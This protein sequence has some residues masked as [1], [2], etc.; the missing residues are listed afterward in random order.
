MATPPRAFARR[1]ITAPSARPHRTQQQTPPSTKHRTWSAAGYSRSRYMPYRYVNVVEGGGITGTQGDLDN[2]GRAD[3][4]AMM[5]GGDLYVYP[6]TGNGWGT[7]R[8]VCG[9][10][11]DIDSVNVADLNLDGKADLVA[12]F[13][14]G[15]IWVYP[16]TGG[17]G[18]TAWGARYLTCGLCGSFDAVNT[19]DVNNDGKPDLVMREAAT[20][21]I[22]LYPNTGAGWGSR[23]LLCGVCGS[24]RDIN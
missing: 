13:R 9:G 20:G 21:N 3:M 15:N 12:R 6:N 23:S 22:Y 11:G 10:C 14:D 4:L 2:A 18:V 16:N 7:R 19:G 1:D 17:P 5:P 8:L 24:W